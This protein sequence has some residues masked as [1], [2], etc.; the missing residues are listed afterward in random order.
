VLNIKASF[1]I[2]LAIT[3]IGIYLIT[4]GLDEKA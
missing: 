3:D 1:K 4:G 2:W